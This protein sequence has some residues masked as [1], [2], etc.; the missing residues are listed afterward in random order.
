M[1]N[2]IVFIYS[3]HLNDEESDDDDSTRLVV[4]AYGIDTTGRNVCLHIHGFCP[5]FF[6]EFSMPDWTDYKA[7]ITGKIKDR[8][9]GPMKTPLSISRK[10]KLYFFQHQKKHPFLR[11]AFP[12]IAARKA[13]FYKLNKY[14]TSIMGKP[15]QLYVH[16]YEASP[17]LQLVCQ[18]DLP[19]AGWIRYNA[20]QPATRKF[21][22]CDAE[23]VVDA[24][25]LYPAPEE[26]SIPT[27]TIM[28]FDIE[29]YS[30]NPK[31]M[32]Q[33]DNRTDCIFQISSS[34]HNGVRKDT[35]DYLITLGKTDQKLVG[36]QV[37]VVHAADEKELLMEWNKLVL[38]T[39]PH[40][41]IGYNIFGFDIPYMIT[42]CKR[43]GIFSRFD[44]LG[45]HA[46]LHAP[47]KEIRWS[48]SAYSHQEFHLLDTEGRLF[49][50]LLPVIKRDYKFA[51]YK[52]KTVSTFFLGETKDPM[53]HLDIFRAYEEGG[54]LL[55]R[56]GKY[57]VQDASLV[58]K[59]FHN[60][61]LWIGL[62]EMATICNVPILYLFTQGQQIKVFSQVYKKGC[63]EGILIQSVDSLS[64]H[65]DVLANDDGYSGAYVFPPAPGVYDWVVPFDFTSLYP[66]TIIAYNIDYS[67]LVLDASVP[68]SECHVIEWDDHIGCPHDTT[69]HA[70]KPTKKLCGHHRFRFKKSPPGV[71][72]SLLKHLLDTRSKTKK[73]IK[74]VGREMEGSPSPSE[75]TR[76]K[77][78]HTSLDKRQLAYKVSANSMYGA[79]GVKKGYMPFIPGAM[80]TTAMG[81]LS[82][83]KAAEFVKQKHQGQL[84][85][86]DS[87]AATTPI[88]TR[89][90]EGALDVV[91]I[92]E[93]FGR[94][95]E[96]DYRE[97]KPWIDAHEKKQSIPA[98]PI[99]VMTA[100]GWARVRRVIRHPTTKR[101]FRI[102]SPRGVVD[103][104]EDHSLLR[105]DHSLATAEELEVGDEL[106]C[107][108]RIEGLEALDVRLHAILR[109]IEV[110]QNAF[111]F[112]AENLCEG[113][114]L[115]LMLRNKYPLLLDYKEGVY[116]IYPDT[117]SEPR[118]CERILLEG[119][120]S[121]VDVYDIETEDGTFM[122]GFGS[123]IVKNTDS[124]YCHFHDVSTAEAV[125]SRAKHIEKQFLQLFPPPMKLVF[126]EK[127]YKV[128]LILTKKR[129]MAYTCD[130]DGSIDEKLTIRGVLLARRDNCRWIREVYEVLVRMI[131]DGAT[132]AMVE[133][134]TIEMCMEIFRRRVPLPRLVITKA[135][136]KDYKIRELPTDPVKFEKRCKDLGVVPPRDADVEEANRRIR[137]A[138]DTEDMNEA[139][140]CE[141]I[142]RSKPAHVQLA[143]KMGRRGHPVEAGTRIE[144]VIVD[145]PDAKAR[146]FEK[147]EDPVYCKKHGDLV[148]IDAMYYLQSLAKPLDQLFTTVFGKKDFLTRLCKIHAA[149]T[150]VMERVYQRDGPKIR[151]VGADGVETTTVKKPRAAAIKKKTIYDD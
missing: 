148:Q 100:G 61:Q 30:S 134:R 94:W 69:V 21:T 97:F 43:H 46:S 22:H 85:Y 24:N 54:K 129:Y 138:A 144:Y 86:G 34:V 119:S 39:N 27:P 110:Q 123:L 33:A 41:I 55:S 116:Y 50:D 15:L 125:W 79:M 112:R 142:A 84:V 109:R 89:S 80:C 9:K 71:I 13:A 2:N 63:K 136:G 81:R 126:E 82:I 90:A 96:Q 31:R 120:A 141:Y 52:L 35:K 122:A 83:Q 93:L 8:Y 106:L 111:C 95:P 56:C 51:N 28:S 108:E 38:K 7:Y 4:R 10:E 150:K 48:S 23:F 145:H 98:E 130:E 32:P 151:L 64:A 146:Q 118:L 139:W 62:V 53:T 140:L 149:W 11:M 19:T 17:L 131:M 77:T 103:V 91:S 105:A 3:W 44:V 45:M 12:S 14:K 133:D 1:E 137:E 37:R 70:T 114:K 117:P 135:V 16:E 42:R 101:M 87:V 49:V 58:L 74:Q 68:D 57:C 5:Y 40:V 73:E 115:Y 132:W 99:E 66:T 75:M 26:T 29:V 25:E 47:E 20:A 78:L 88:L 6:L 143:A 18:R 128:F 72:P 107:A 65:A 60:L 36:S 147:I 104:T 127:I 113:M 102:V 67:T 92:A 59:L 121:P 76:L 124:I